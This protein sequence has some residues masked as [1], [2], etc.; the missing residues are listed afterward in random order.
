[1]FDTDTVVIGAGVVG[2]ACAAAIAESGR[3]TIVLERTGMIG[4]GISSRNSEVIHAGIY[5]PTGSVRHRM[6]VEGRRRLYSYVEARNVAYRK[7]G[8]L[9]V[10][11]S[12]AETAK[13]EALYQTGL[14]NDVEGLQLLSGAD[15]MAMQPEL[16]CTAAL[17]S[18]ETGIIDSHGLMLALQGQFEDTG[19]MIAF[20]SPAERMTPL[21]GGGFRLETGGADPGEL[22]C[23]SVVNAAGLHAQHVARQIDGLDPRHVPKQVLAKGNY[24]RFAGKSA[25]S[26]LI[27]PAPVDGGL[28]VHLTLDIGGQMRFG[29][30]VEWLAHA[31]P[32]AVEYSVDPRRSDAFYAAVRRYWPDLPDNS[33][34][35]DYSG[36]RPKLFGPGETAADFLVSDPALHGIEGLVNLFG[37]ESPGLTSS[38][39]IANRV[40]EL[41]A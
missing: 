24:F 38:L 34:V 31:D 5:Y 7:T 8:K 25:F 32:D 9:I 35:P 15:A 16:S 41:T 23:R 11:T 4:S 17:W 13:I 36:C 18:P 37:I 22:T 27:Y 14:A 33:L 19:G 40:K 12:P 30:D 29:P 3:E 20:Q 21:A 1:M 39:A 26:S 10:A 6:C 28:G 2:L